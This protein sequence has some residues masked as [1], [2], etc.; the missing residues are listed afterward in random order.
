MNRIEFN[1]VL[2]ALEINKVLST[3]LGRN[4]TSEICYHWQDILINFSGT[5]YAEIHGK[6]PYEVAERI[7]EKYPNNPYEIRI[8]GGCVDYKPSEWATDDKYNN[9]I[10]EYLEQNLSSEEYLKKCKN[11]R[12]N[13]IR[14][15]NDNKFIDTYHIDSKEGLV[16]LLT[17]MKDYYARKRGL[18]EIEVQRFNELM[19][20]VNSEI[21][22]KVNPNI[23]TNDWMEQD[24]ENKKIFFQTIANGTKTSFGKQFREIIEDFDRT[25]NPFI[26]EYIT[27]DEVKNYIQKVNISANTYDSPEVKPRE[28][29]CQLHITDLET[30]NK[31]S[32]YRGTGGFSYQLM[33]K[34]DE[35]QYL[36]VLHY[37]STIGEH[38]NDKGEI[39]AI[40]YWGDKTEKDIDIRYNIT[41]GVV[42]TTYGEKTPI[43]PEQKE[44]IYDELVKAVDY[45]E[46]ITINNM[47]KS[48]Y[49][50]LRLI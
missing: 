16:I 2:K 47:K 27:L 40:E 4:G 33:Y 3:S 49:K 32:Y 30:Q 5:Y 34:L 11:S 10:Q 39:I 29:S 44:F 45:A 13:L 48:K 36:I 18:P 8:A 50:T 19:T 12:R 25:V 1:E 20:I 14:R 31:V 22:K 35:E 15:K 37:F 21:L 24:D 26:N 41:K 7:Y 6:I 9:E 17:E 42:G 46:T 43:S 28:N 23:S 38:E